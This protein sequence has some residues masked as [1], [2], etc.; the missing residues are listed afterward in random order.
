[1]LRLRHMTLL[2]SFILNISSVALPDG[3]TLIYLAAICHLG[4]RSYGGHK[5]QSAMDSSSILSKCFG[6]SNHLDRNDGKLCSRLNNSEFI[7][8][9]NPMTPFLKR[10][11]F[12][13]RS[14]LR[15]SETQQPGSQAEKAPKQHTH[16][17]THTHAHTHTEKNTFSH[18]AQKCS[19]KDGKQAFQR[20]E[21]F[22]IVEW[23]LQTA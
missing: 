7:L 5:Q 3:T 23:L 13:Y 11:S 14:V 6:H 17:H 9:L 18:V 10:L 15:I 22:L 20:Q 8:I 21:P 16:T 12:T 4:S 2:I 1:M 19:R